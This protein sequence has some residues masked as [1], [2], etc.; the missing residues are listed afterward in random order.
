MN[1]TV[2]DKIAALERE[3]RYRRR[4]YQRQVELGKLTQKFADYQIAIFEA[5]LMD[6]LAPMMKNR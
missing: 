5:I 4:V 1:F 3:I 2:A 6:Y